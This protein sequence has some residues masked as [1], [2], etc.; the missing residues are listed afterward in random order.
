MVK[1]Q[2]IA[3]CYAMLFGI[4]LLMIVFEKKIPICFAAYGC[5]DIFKKS[6]NISVHV[7]SDPLIVFY[8]EKV[9]H[10]VVLV[11]YD[12]FRCKFSFHVFMHLN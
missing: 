4:L 7:L 10:R 6:S 11:N 1:T 2:G 8:S 5:T 12:G 9:F 3:S